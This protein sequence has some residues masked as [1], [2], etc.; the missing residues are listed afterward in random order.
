MSFNA[1]SKDFLL[2]CK[3][4]SARIFKNNNVEFVS[5]EDYLKLGITIDKIFLINP[6]LKLL[7]RK[8]NTEFSTIEANEYRPNFRIEWTDTS[9]EWW[10]DGMFKGMLE[11]NEIDRISGVMKSSTSIEKNSDRYRKN[12]ISYMESTYKCSV[13]DKIF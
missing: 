13:L 1:Y 2:E 3:F 7:K 8:H 10:Y 6:Q 9:V 5:R 11:S 4:E 12:G